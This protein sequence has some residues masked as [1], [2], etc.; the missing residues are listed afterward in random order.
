M[1]RFTE[2]SNFWN[3]AQVA[4][5]KWQMF[6]ETARREEKLSPTKI[7]TPWRVREVEFFK[8]LPEAERNAYMLKAFYGQISGNGY[9]TWVVNEYHYYNPLVCE[10]LEKV[11]KPACLSAAQNL[12]SMSTQNVNFEKIGREFA[13]NK[14][15]FIKEVEEYFQ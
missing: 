13:A 12:T 1:S 9:P 14:A 6:W 3:L 15:A 5:E 8:T 7:K 4:T 11:G 10:A 2:D